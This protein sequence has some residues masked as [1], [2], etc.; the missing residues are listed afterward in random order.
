MFKVKASTQDPAITN[1]Y[2]GRMDLFAVYGRAYDF[3]RVGL[4]TKVAADADPDHWLLVYRNPKTPIREFD[5]LE[6][7]SAFLNRRH[8]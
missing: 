6:E 8:S 5:T 3:I 1:V 4:V 7:L 2:N